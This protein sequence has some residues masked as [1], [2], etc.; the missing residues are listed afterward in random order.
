MVRK[1]RK[2]YTLMEMMM[3]V[4]ILGIVITTAAPLM[5]QTT[6][7]W[8]LTS[9]RF[10]IQRDVRTSIDL[11]NRF[12][13]QA[14]SATVVVDSASGQPPASRIT[15]SVVNSTGATVSV[16]FYQTGKK[17]YM[18]NNGNVSKLSDNLAYIAFTYPKSDDISII[19]VA[20]TMQSPTYKGGKKALQL[21]IQKVRIM[22]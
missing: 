11:I 20:M 8:K 10:A 7:F 4:A 14:Q 21:S 22:N 9:A 3:V 1:S 12:T 2:G 13:R 15:F 5:Y 17:L 6:N 18:N 16:S 19:S